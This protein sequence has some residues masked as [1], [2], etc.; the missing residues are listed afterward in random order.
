MPKRNANENTEASQ[1]SA[2]DELLARVDREQNAVHQNIEEDTVR[3]LAEVLLN[4]VSL[5]LIQVDISPMQW[6]DAHNVYA[7]G[8]RATYMLSNLHV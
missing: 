2:L 3:A 5:L 1:Q 4:Q 7:R 6:T 8:V